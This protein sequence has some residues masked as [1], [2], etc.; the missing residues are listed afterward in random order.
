MKTIQRIKHTKGF[1]II[2]NGSIRDPRLSLSALGLLLVMLSHPDTWDFHLKQL[3]ESRGAGITILTRAMNELIACGYVTRMTYVMGD[4][5]ERE[6]F[7]LSEVPSFQE[8]FD[9]SNVIG[10]K[11]KSLPDPTGEMLVSL[12]ELLSKDALYNNNQ[13][14]TE[15]KRTCSAAGCGHAASE[16]RSKRGRKPRS[17]GEQGPISEEDIKHLFL[18]LSK[19]LDEQS[20]G[21]QI[22]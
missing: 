21:S 8:G 20:F 9:Y 15:K 10:A 7:L 3:G 11:D 6:G 1:T 18:D 12:G 2:D 17:Q 4:G 5:K 13:Y 22:P 14:H 16:R 19:E